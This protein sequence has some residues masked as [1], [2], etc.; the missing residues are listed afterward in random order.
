MCKNSF[1]AP[2]TPN[3]LSLQTLLQPFHSNSIREGHAHGP[4][5]MEERND[6]IWDSENWAQAI[7]RGFEESKPLRSTVNSC[8]AVLFPVHLPWLQFPPTN[9]RNYCYF[10]KRVV[11]S[12]TRLFWEEVN[13]W[14]SEY[15]W[16]SNESYPSSFSGQGQLASNTMSNIYPNQ[17]VT[18]SVYRRRQNSKLNPKKKLM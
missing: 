11:V 9:S 17:S 3:P 18:N 16:R 8:D 10:Q 5:T 12:F 6:P 15:D 4:S 13:Q 14:L 2:L 1:R 7:S